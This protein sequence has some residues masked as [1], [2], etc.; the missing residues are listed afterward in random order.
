M[1]QIRKGLNGKPLFFWTVPFSLKVINENWCKGQG[2]YMLP[3]SLIVFHRHSKF[4]SI[5]VYNTKMSSLSETFRFWGH[6]LP[7]SALIQEW[8]EKETKK[9]EPQNSVPQFCLKNWFN[10]FINYPRKL[11]R[12]LWY[13]SWLFSHSNLNIYF[14]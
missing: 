14:F 8:C 7:L 2:L 11:Y 4:V 13:G 1:N 5:Q 10:C 9:L 3:P 6:F 12:I